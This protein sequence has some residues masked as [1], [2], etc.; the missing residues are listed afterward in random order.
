[1]KYKVIEAPY[2]YTLMERVQDHL[3]GGWKPQGG[4]GYQTLGLREKLYQALIKD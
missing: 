1:M 4:V 3:D 2:M